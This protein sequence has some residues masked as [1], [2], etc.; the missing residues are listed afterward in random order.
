MDFPDPDCPRRQKGNRSQGWS[1]LLGHRSPCRC[2]RGSP[3]VGPDGSC[4]TDSLQRPVVMSSDY[5]VER[6]TFYLVGTTKSREESQ[7]NFFVYYEEIKREINRIL[8]I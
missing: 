6:V 2:D 7:E 3:Q 4:Y 8:S 1:S 5:V